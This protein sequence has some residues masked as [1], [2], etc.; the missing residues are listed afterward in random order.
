MRLLRA[1]DQK[2]RALVVCELRFRQGKRRDV[3]LNAAMLNTDNRAAA[4]AAR[5]ATDIAY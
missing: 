2:S 5:A 1:R 4:N 3:E